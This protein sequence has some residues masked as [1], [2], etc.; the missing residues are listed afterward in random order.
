MSF[1][2]ETKSLL[3]SQPYKNSCCRRSLLNGILFAKGYVSG[4]DVCLSLEN[5][6]VVE[7]VGT[8]V[9]EFFGKEITVENPAVGGRRKLIKFKSPACEKYLSLISDTDT[10]N[11]SIKCQGCSSAFYCGVFLACGRVM[12]PQKRYRLEFAPETR[13]IALKELLS[14]IAGDFSV[15]DQK[16]QTV[17]Y[18]A[19]STVAE[20]FFA[21]IGMNTTAFAF[22]NSKIEKDIKNTAQRVAN[23]EMNNISK[24]VD[25]AAKYIN[26][27][28]A[29][30]SA[31]LLSTLPDELEKTARLRLLY[32]DYSLARLAAEFTPPISKP[33]LSH[34]LNK[35]LEIFEN[36][37]GAKK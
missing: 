2:S 12:N 28:E 4:A 32:R 3:I 22:M 35:I 9:K 29:L 17:L 15:A 23:C 27:I 30:D 6:L 19:N 25:A 11:I 33:G 21:S 16:G 31:N 1:S 20:D 24:T 37:V 36:T 13:H 5:S 14:R 26:A 34:R 18:S 7:Y 10:V 8:L